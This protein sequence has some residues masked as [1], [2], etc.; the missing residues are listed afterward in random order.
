MFNR[1]PHKR[2]SQSLY[3]VLLFAAAAAMIGLRQCST[4]RIP[5]RTEPLAGG[6]TLNV[7]IEISPMGV[8]MRGDTLGGYYYDMV[9]ELSR[10]MNRP[11][12]FHAF[13]QLETALNA[14]K[15]GRYRLV[16]TDIPAI[17]ELK[18]EFLFVQPGEIDRQ[19]LVQLKD[20]TGRTPF[21]TQFDLAGNTVTVPKSSPFISRLH[22]L[23]RESGETIHIVE[24][25]QYSS[26]QLIILTALGE[27]PN[28]VTSARVVQPLLKEYPQLDAS[29]GI[30]FNQFQGW[31]MAPRDS[32]LRDSIMTALKSMQAK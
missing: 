20:S 16:V 22:N 15:D 9:N 28:V 12:R 13:T 14:L 24:D 1:L 17:S 2:G 3:L 31:A 4:R 25:P 21:R 10:T 27:V 32:L 23:A 18:E 26:E 29:L 6:D 5:E 11:V 30:S 19:V 7:A 8:I